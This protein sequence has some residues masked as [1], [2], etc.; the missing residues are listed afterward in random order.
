ME[1]DT[2]FAGLSG[3]T[4]AAGLFWLARQTGADTK[5]A[6]ISNGLAGVAANETV[7][8]ALREVHVLLIEHPG[9]RKYFYAEEEEGEA[10]E[11]PEEE[12][13][14]SRVMTIAEL[15]LD[16]LCSG[17]DTHRKVPNSNSKE[18][19]EAYCRQMLRVSPV[20]RGLVRRNPAFWPLL[21]EL[22]PPSP[23]PDA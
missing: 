23:P 8:T 15:L 13:A 2:L 6:E 4:A 3:L 12:D 18:P 22:L 21:V 20:V 11:C 5:Q 17:V 16:V 1:L 9:L 7:L 10:A 14:K 19:W